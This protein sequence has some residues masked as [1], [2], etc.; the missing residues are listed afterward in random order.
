MG[1]NSSNQF[2]RALR[3]GDHVKAS[4]LYHTKVRLKENLQPNLS[5]GVEHNENTL[6]HYAALYGMEQMYSDLISRQGKPDMKN[7]QRRNCLHLICL[8]STVRGIEDH[9]KCAM[10]ELTFKEGLHGMDIKHLLAEKDEVSHSRDGH[11]QFN[12][13]YTNHP[14][15]LLDTL[16][17]CGI[18][19]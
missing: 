16:Q 5:L 10:L 4:E 9:T 7:C 2:L 6:L 14:M 1:N 15:H 19:S 8:C 13:P 11:M 12:W 17:V 18:F 3:H